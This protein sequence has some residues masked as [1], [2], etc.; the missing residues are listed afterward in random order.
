MKM[1]A[2]RGRVGLA[3]G[4]GGQAPGSEERAEQPAAKGPLRAL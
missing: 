4:G 1:A 2:R 3:G